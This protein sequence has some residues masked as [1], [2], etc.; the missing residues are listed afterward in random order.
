MFEANELQH[1]SNKNNSSGNMPRENYFRHLRK[2]FLE[3]PRCCYCLFWTL[4]HCP[5][6]YNSPCAL[7]Q[8]LNTTSRKQHLSLAWEIMPYYTPGRVFVLTKYRRHAEN[9]SGSGRLQ[10]AS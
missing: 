5:M 7:L 1:A 8:R 4:H 10:N 3:L 6:H 2:N 9:C